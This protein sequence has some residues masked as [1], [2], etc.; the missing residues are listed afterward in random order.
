M[1]RVGI[2]T[3]HDRISPVFDVARNLLVVEMQDGQE[4]GRQQVE[5][6][7]TAPNLRALEVGKLDLNVLI[8]GA[9]SQP[10]ENMLLSSGTHIFS[11]LCG[12][13]EEIFQAFISGNWA[14]REFLMPGCGRG[15][16]RGRGGGGGG[17]G[18]GRGGGRGQGRGGGGGGRGQGR[19]IGGGNQNRLGERL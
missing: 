18:Q 17:R 4:V 7:E 8:C 16:G 19:G 11:H 14:E 13:T 5:L 10:L 3:W 9:V 6:K 2:T 15:L 1:M 12:E